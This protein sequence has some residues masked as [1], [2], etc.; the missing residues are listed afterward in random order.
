MNI[1]HTLAHEDT[2]IRH[3]YMTIFDLERFGYI[4]Y[5]V[6]VIV[7]N[8]ITFTRFLAGLFD[9]RNL[10]LDKFRSCLLRLLP[11]ILIMSL[12]L[13]EFTDEI[14]VLDVFKSFLANSEACILNL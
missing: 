6:N 5:K 2:H 11:Y 9:L 12:N 13:T 10:Y 3:I 7:D 8:I 14:R 1:A 4:G